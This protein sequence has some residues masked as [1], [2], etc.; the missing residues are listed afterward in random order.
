MGKRVVAV[1]AIL[2]PLDMIVLRSTE[3]RWATVEVGQLSQRTMAV[4]T[5]TPTPASS[6]ML[7]L[8]EKSK[9][10]QHRE[11]RQKHSKT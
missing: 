10:L 11:L 1:G 7:D 3:D 5:Y 2:K 8:L 9:T 6:K 4:K